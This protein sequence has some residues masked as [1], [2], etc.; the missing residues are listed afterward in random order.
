MA[1]E[2]IDL[3]KTGLLVMDYQQLLVDGYVA[4]PD[5]ALSRAAEVMQQSRAADI[6]VFYVTVGFRPGYPE[7]SDRNM[8]FSGVRAGERFRL[9]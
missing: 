7:V 5:A 4:N 1:L 8:M 9:G 3:N 2:N 6:P